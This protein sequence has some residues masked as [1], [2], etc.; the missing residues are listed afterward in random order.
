MKIADSTI[1]PETYSTMM[2]NQMMQN[3]DFFGKNKDE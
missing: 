2:M 3:M 1:P